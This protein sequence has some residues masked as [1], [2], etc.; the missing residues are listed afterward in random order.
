[1]TAEQYHTQDL[2]RQEEAAQHHKKIGSSRWG[3]HLKKLSPHQ[4]TY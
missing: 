4:M 1:L 2:Y 3:K